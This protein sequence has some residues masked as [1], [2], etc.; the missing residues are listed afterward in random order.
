MSTVQDIR[1]ALRQLRRAPGFALTAILTLG[2]GLGAAAT[3]LSVV[4]SVLLAPLPYPAPDR[5]VGVAFTFPQEKPNAEQAGASADFLAQHSHSFASVGIAEDSVGSVNLSYSGPDTTH[6]IQVAEQRVSHGYLPTL[7]VQPAFGRGFTADEDRHN[8]PRSVLISDALWQRAFRRDPSILNHTIRLNE[9]AYT[10]IGIMPASLR[11]AGQSMNRAAISPDVWSALQ[12][13]PQDPGYDGDNYQLI[14]RLAPGVSLAQAQAE[15]AS[16]DQPFYHQFPY[17]LRWTT[18]G[19]LLHGYKLWPLQ[20]VLASDVRSSLLTLLAAVV[21]VLLVA[22][23]N[24]A[25][26]AS[27][28]AIGRT[29]ELVL[30][31]SL[32]ASR[33]SLLRLLLTESFVLAVAGALLG[34][35]I[36]RAGTPALLAASPIAIPLLHAQASFLELASGVLLLSLATTLVF[37]LLPALAVSRSLFAPAVQATLSSGHSTGATRA[38]ARLGRTLIIAQ[39]AFAMMLLSAA[40]LL[41]G[42]FLKLRSIPS[43]VVPEH[44]VIAQVTLKGDHYAS[45]LHTTQFVEKVLGQLASTPG[46]KQ[47]AAISGL[48]LD[49]GLNFGARPVDQ[50]GHNQ[51]IGFRA[52]TPGYFRT[53]GIALLAGRDLTPDDRANT[54]PVAVISET[55]ARRWWP[56]RT[57]IGEQV[58]IGNET[59]YR[60]VGIVRDTR[61]NSLAEEPSIMIYAP[62]AQFSDAMTR[63]INGWIS[64]TF[65]VR[66]AADVD[67]AAAAQQALTAADPEIPVARL[68][69]MQSVIDQSLAAPRFFSWLSG[70]FAGFALLLTVIGLF[71]LLSYQVTVRTREIGVRMALGADRTRILAGIV[72]SGVML[73][74]VGLALGL[75]GSVLVRRAVASVLED[76]IFTG[77]DPISKILVSS[78]YTLA[79]A[80]LAILLA[81]VVAS[82][83][84][85]RRAASIDPMQALRSE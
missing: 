75:A 80:T 33:T 27:S 44:L 83:L 26:L 56:G 62:Y 78:T 68:S 37:G 36:A 50:P 76:S 52:I 61:N 17:Y 67:L 64:T 35:V 59:N 34:L 70:G 30:R 73:S 71:G 6:S 13:D 14:A 58:R 19:K 21:A 69:T 1:Y 84:P 24:L 3:M 25:G 28:R 55:A 60:I 47:A 15:I 51:E 66:T 5:L 48:P 4:E 65:A 54:P 45:T 11:I 72:R 46:V 8:G 20:Q 38:Q 57:A 53:A 42:T 74:L 31:A 41:L 63:I 29:R 23:L 82:F 81:A 12:L 39:V 32:G 16:F 10:V 2:L 9:D 85:A 77:D 18:P 49:R 7:G 79:A 40:S 43:G 22:C